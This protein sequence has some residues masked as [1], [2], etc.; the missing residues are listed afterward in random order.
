MR[1]IVITYHCRILERRARKEP[2]FSYI[3]VYYWL[4]GVDWHRIEILSS[5][6]FTHDMVRMY[7]VP[8]EQY[9]N[10]LVAS[11]PS[12]RFGDEAGRPHT[13]L[14]TSPGGIRRRQSIGI[15]GRSLGRSRAMTLFDHVDTTPYHIMP[16][17]P[18]NRMATGACRRNHMP[19]TKLVAVMTSHQASVS[20]ETPS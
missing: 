16:M 18:P 9:H 10:I 13:L 19:P 8:F 4:Y 5:L 3:S 7:Q 2:L 14:G 12:G 1:W 6:R 20:S 11:T 17:T 15:M